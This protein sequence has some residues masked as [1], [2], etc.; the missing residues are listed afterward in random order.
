LIPDLMI[1]EIIRQSGPDV[2]RVKIVR[3]GNDVC[4]DAA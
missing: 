3:N 1:G 4:W 2:Q